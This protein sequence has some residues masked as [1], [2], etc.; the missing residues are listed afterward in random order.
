MEHT[1]YF[2][3]AAYFVIDQ[4]TAFIWAIQPQLLSNSCF[5]LSLFLL[6]KRGFLFCISS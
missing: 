6:S 2:Y 5:S 1:H 3:L 4:V